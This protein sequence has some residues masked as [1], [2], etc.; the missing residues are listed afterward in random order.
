MANRSSTRRKIVVENTNN[1]VPAP[2]PAPAQGS[3]SEAADVRKQTPPRTRGAWF[4][5]AMMLQI[6]R[7]ASD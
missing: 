5:R 2:A 3:A 1:N 4:Q 6:Q 7:P